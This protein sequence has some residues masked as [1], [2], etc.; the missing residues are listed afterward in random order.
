MVCLLQSKAVD[1]GECG[2][3][4]GVA[5]DLTK[6]NAA[7]YLKGL[8]KIKAREI[9]VCKIAAKNANVRPDIPVRT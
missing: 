2:F 1:N 4:F 3:F 9:P 7:S 5:E 6:E 8:C